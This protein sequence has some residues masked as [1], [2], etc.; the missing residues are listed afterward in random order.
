MTANQVLHIPQVIKK[1]A[2]DVKSFLSST[3]IEV[4]IFNDEEYIS[5]GNLLK[6]IKQKEREITA[7]YREV[8]APIVKAGRD[9]DQYF[10]P[11]LDDVSSKCK[12]LGFAMVSYECKKKEIAR[13]Q[14][15]KEEKI[16]REAQAKL[17]EKASAEI[18]KA[19]ELRASG[20]DN[21]AAAKDA[22][23]EALINRAETVVA[24]QPVLPPAPTVQGVSVRE[25][26]KGRVTDL[27]M[28]LSWAIESKNIHFVL[29]NESALNAQARAIKG[30]AQIPGVEWYKETSSIVRG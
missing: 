21:L 20:N 22:N 1:I 26:W 29:V 4:K 13:I 15:E 30:M 12:M 6:T 19:E 17:L 5:A 2:A 24:E 28:F 16:A 18:K 7:A 8:K 23:A 14:R 27:K 10:K 25:V 9:A 3:P 11:I